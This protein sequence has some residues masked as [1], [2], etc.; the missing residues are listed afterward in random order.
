MPDDYCPLASEKIDEFKL[1]IYTLNKKYNFLET[2]DSSNFFEVNKFIQKYSFGLGWWF[3]V[4]L[5]I[6][7]LFNVVPAASNLIN[8][9]LKKGG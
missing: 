1:E 7:D 3:P 6:G 5:L 8:I 2:L 4:L 9:I